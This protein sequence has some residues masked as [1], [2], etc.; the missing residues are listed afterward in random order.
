MK[1]T[2]LEL[3]SGLSKNTIRNIIVF[4][5][6]IPVISIC[7]G[8]VVTGLLVI[9]YIDKVIQPAQYTVNAENKTT[10]VEY[11]LLQAGVFMN[12]ENADILQKGIDR[13]NKSTFVVNNGDSFR[14]IVDISKN[15]DDLEII[16]D[17]LKTSGYNC[18]IN[19]I[20]FN[21]GNSDTA[22]SENIKN[23]IELFELEYEAIINIGNNKEVSADE[24]INQRNKIIDIYKKI[25]I[26]NKDQS[27]VNPMADNY[28]SIVKKTDE[29]IKN[30]ESKKV[31][32]LKS[33]LA[34]QI[35]IYKSIYEKYTESK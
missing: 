2:R 28:K 11:Y 20:S 6:I 9:P 16:Q 19:S 17:N 8:K 22:F 26:E 13:A 18:I 21:S 3:H 15:K 34:D 23:I 35:F 29:F 25:E 1:Y 12:R 10:E 24:I 32:D 30:C 31:I 5:T 7:I 33:C 4:F 14:I 27:K